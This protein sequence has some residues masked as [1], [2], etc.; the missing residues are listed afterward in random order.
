L[1]QARE[2]R[3]VVAGILLTG[4]ASRRMGV[5]KATLVVD[6]ETLAARAARVLAA[7]CDPVIEVG[8]GV[9][10]LPAVREDPPGAGPLAALVA[11]AGALGALPVVL[12][13]CD[14]PFVDEPLLRLLAQ[15]PG[16]G[17]V[18]PVADGRFQYAC[19]RYGAAAI[20]EANA[21]LRSGHGGLK[22]ATDATVTY[23]S[24]RE[25]QAV[26]PAHAFADFDT[27]GD[28]A[29]FGRDGP[30]SVGVHAVT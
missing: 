19:A 10:G 23:L 6:G 26:A 11:G 18:V 15:W 4:G 24:E 13:A 9:S 2:D 22:H 7:V 17:T 1:N 14:M 27:P 20:D 16:D 25:W 29:R 28:I 30:R 5:D 8:S 12:L 21:A 3:G